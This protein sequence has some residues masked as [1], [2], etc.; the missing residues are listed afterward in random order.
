ML[1]SLIGVYPT[2]AFRFIEKL[3]FAKSMFPIVCKKNKTKTKAKA[4]LF[5]WEVDENIGKEKPELVP[6][7]AWEKSCH[8]SGCHDQFVK[9]RFAG[10]NS[11]SYLSSF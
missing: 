11:I 9:H 3:G 4:A 5:M 1:T 10:T 7:S 6:G 8:G 2:K